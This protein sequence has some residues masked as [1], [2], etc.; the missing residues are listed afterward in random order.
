MYKIRCKI[1]LSICLPPLN[2]IQTKFRKKKQ[3]NF[4][5]QDHTF[6]LSFVQSCAWS[7][8][9]F[10]V[11]RSH[12]DDKWILFFSIK[13]QTIK[14]TDDFIDRQE[15]TK[16]ITS[17]QKAENVRHKNQNKNA[18]CSFR[19]FLFFTYFFTICFHL[20]NKFFFY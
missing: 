7:S 20:L 3:M 11:N 1:V 14:W 10:L 16:Q 4:S 15:N 18:A 6:E 8:A 17:G 13:S 5:S 2:K 12:C 19:S 9:L